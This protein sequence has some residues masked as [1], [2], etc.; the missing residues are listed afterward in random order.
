MATQGQAR[1]NARSGSGSSN[2]SSNGGLSGGVGLVGSASS[3]EPI[4]YLVGMTIMTFLFAIMLPVMMFMYIDM[5]TIKRENEII[6]AKIGKY[7]V[8]I[9]KCSKD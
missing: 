5:K 4:G 7:T 2:R 3:E 9:H 1:S 8:L 6:K